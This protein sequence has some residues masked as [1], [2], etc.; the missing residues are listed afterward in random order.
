MTK[1]K[2]KLIKTAI[3]TTLLGTAVAIGSVIGTTSTIMN[4]QGDDAI[5]DGKGFYGGSAKWGQM[6]AQGKYSIQARTFDMQ[7]NIKTSGYAEIVLDGKS[8]I[9]KWSTLGDDL[10]VGDTTIRLD[11]KISDGYLVL[12]NGHL[13]QLKKI[14]NIKG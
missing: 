6:I 11:K 12:I 5:F 2:V 14:K 13:V 8:H 9:L 7:M 4:Y 3:A 1:T 10:T